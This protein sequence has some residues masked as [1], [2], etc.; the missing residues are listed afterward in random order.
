MYFHLIWIKEKAWK[1]YELNLLLKWWD[2]D[3]I[4]SFLAHR[5]VVIV[6]LNKFEW[7]TASFGNISMSILF[8]NKEIQILMN[9]KDLSERLYFIAFLWLAPQFV[10]FVDNPIPE[11]QMNELIK[12]TFLKIKEENEKLKQ[13]QEEEFEKEQKKYEE[14]SIKDW[15]KII[16]SNIDHIEQVIK[17]WAWILSSIEVKQLENYLN[18]M[19]RIRLWTNFNKMASL[20]LD[21][22][23]LVRNAEEQIFDAYKDKKF[24]VDERSS[25]TNIDVMSE[26]YK[27]SRA[28]DKTTFMPKALTTTETV[29]GVLGNASVFLQL[30]RRDFIST[31]DRT[32]FDEFFDVLMEMIEFWVIT[33]TVIICFSRFV[34]NIFGVGEFSLYSL[35]AFWWLWLLIYLFNSLNLKWPIARIWGLVILIAIYRYWLVLLMN[36]FAL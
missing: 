21:A 12:S 26:Y 25:V 1:Q 27:L 17:A 22:H 6:S 8:E 36:T 30:L 20:V 16:N 9:W 5:W 23:V 19:K 4:R 11:L 29:Y 7:E 10:N 34:F 35:P 3:F 15:L 28:K 18:E 31:F 33:T 2:E 32:S 13:W 14:S 24:L